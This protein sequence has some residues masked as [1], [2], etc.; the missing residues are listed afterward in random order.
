MD[1]ILRG[2][3]FLSESGPSIGNVVL[4]GQGHGVGVQQPDQ[5]TTEY[6]QSGDQMLMDKFHQENKDKL[7]ILPEFGQHLTHEFLPSS[8]SLSGM[9]GNSRISSQILLS[10][11]TSSSSLQVRRNSSFLLT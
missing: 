2:N 4:D 3:P 1:E 5:L 10:K 8:P 6:L 7:S 11:K 9:F